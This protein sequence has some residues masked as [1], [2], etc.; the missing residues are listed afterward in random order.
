VKASLATPAPPYYVKGLALG[1]PAILLILHGHFDFSSK[2]GRYMLRTGHARE[3]YDYGAEKTFQDALVSR[4]QIAL[5]FNHLAYEAPLF[6]PF[7]LL[8]FRAA[9]FAFLAV[10]LTLF[11]ICGRRRTMRT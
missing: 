5:P 8:P 1:I 9:Y 4:E 6:A 7:S 2:S 3:L 10:N 11:R